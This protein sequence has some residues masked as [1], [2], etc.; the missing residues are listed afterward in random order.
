VGPGAGAAPWGD[1]T[2][3]NDIVRTKPGREGFID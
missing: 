1:G 2:N 3:W